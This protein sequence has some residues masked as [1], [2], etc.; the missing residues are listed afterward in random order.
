MLFIAAVLLV[1]LITGISFKLGY[2]SNDGYTQLE[3]KIFVQTYEILE[4][5]GF[6]PMPPAQT[7]EYEMIRDLVKAYDDP[8]TVFVE[9][10]QHEIESDQLD[11]KFGGSGVEIQR[12]SDDNIRF[13]QTSPCPQTG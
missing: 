4:R 2:C 7:I 13:N 3:F 6:K 12:D 9:P 10:V 5:N 1:V 11:G 8:F